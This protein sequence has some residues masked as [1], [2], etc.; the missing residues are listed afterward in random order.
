[1]EQD[2]PRF[3]RQHFERFLLALDRHLAGPFRLDII[4]EAVAVLSFNAESGTEDIDAVSN[5]E[6][7]ENALKAAR[8]ET[9]LDIPLT[10]VAIYDAPYHYER[11]LKRVRIPGL[12]KLQ[13]FAPEKHDWALIKITRFLRKDADDIMEVARTM[14]FD[15]K[16]FLKRFISEMTH[17]TGRREDLIYNF[18]TMMDEIFGNEEAI[19]MEGAI[20][21]SKEWR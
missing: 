8:D 2:V 20:K 16:V 12:T 13:V 4:G 21:R 6:P 7:I 14:G 11:R 1:M 10:T 18:L 17:V 3:D 9:G 19:R 15:N 5:V